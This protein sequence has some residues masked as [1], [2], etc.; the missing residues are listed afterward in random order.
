M[1]TDEKTGV[2]I[3]AP[4]GDTLIRATM[5]PQ[6]LIP[7]LMDAIRDTPEYV[8]LI[9]VIPHHVWE[10]DDDVWWGGEFCSYFLNE[11][12]WDVVDS[13]AP[14]GYYFGCTEGDSSDYGY[15]EV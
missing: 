13:Y 9:H 7:A 10:D 11:Q 12:L 2:I 1:F 14:D 5:R 15:W 4:L 3:H 6:D 8:Q